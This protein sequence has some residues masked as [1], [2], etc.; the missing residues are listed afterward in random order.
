MAPPQDEQ[1]ALTNRTRE[2]YRAQSFKM[3]KEVDGHTDATVYRTE[4]NLDTE[5]KE[6]KMEDGYIETTPFIMLRQKIEY[7]KVPAQ[8]HEHA[9]VEPFAAPP[10]YGWYSQT[11]DSADVER[12]GRYTDTIDSD[13]VR[14]YDDYNVIIETTQST[15]NEGDTT[16][17]NSTESEYNA[18]TIGR[19]ISIPRPCTLS[20]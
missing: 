15:T 5:S 6:S 12:E 16:V 20:F 18:T 3:T 13:D 7:A 10:Q 11:K 8:R 9:S 17:T 4:R 19:Q 14:Q 1:T 2:N